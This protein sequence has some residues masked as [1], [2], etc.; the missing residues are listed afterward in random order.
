[1]FMPVTQNKPAPYAP[2]KAILEV[3]DRFRNRGMQSPVNSDVLAR[4][5]V[6]DSLIPR[7][8]QSLQTLDLIDDEGKPTDT[9]EGL[10]MAP[11]GEYKARLGE[12]LKG[13]YAEVFSFVDPAQDDEIRVRDAFR[14]YQPIG[15]QPR[16]V[17][18]FL[19]L[20]NAA[21][22]VAEKGTATARAPSTTPKRNPLKRTA[23]K[24]TPQI[25]SST[26]PAP[27][28]GLLSQLPRQG[29]GWSK[30]RR[31]QFLHTFSAVLD[32][33]FPVTATEAHK[34]EQE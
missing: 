21:G 1:M 34:E 17:T 16:M 3:M 2:P 29:E 27:I 13:A 10:R 5:G 28:T 23:P 14:S 24:P 25:T 7:T 11:E 8:L 18:L 33:C 12:W 32:F 19:G 4:A 15:M 31:E 26:L 20:C 22:L 6:S 9:F 30:K